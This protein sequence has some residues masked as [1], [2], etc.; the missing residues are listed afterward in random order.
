[1]S[2]TFTDE[3]TEAQKCQS[4]LCNDTGNLEEGNS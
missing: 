2:L 4:D 1:M 3:G